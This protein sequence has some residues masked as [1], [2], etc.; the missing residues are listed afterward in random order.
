MQSLRHARVS[1]LLKREIGT[2]L[3]RELSVETSGV[4]SVNQVSVAPD[5]KSAVVYVGFVGSDIQRKHA[6]DQLRKHRGRLQSQVA[7]SLV[8]KYMPHI[9]FVS[10]D[11]L[12]RGDRVLQILDE[13]EKIS[14][15]DESNSEDR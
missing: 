15:S 2:V 5:L 14:P 4:I 6:F 8:L 3:R 1:E 12:Q 11:S 7:K 9:K 10:D 13:L